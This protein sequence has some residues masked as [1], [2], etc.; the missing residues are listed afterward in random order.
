MKSPMSE[1]LNRATRN[2]R[3]ADLP[4]MVLD[5]GDL[6]ADFQA[7][8]LARQGVLDNAAMAEQ[9]FPGN[10]VETFTALGRISGYLREFVAPMPAGEVIPPGY[11]LAVA[12]V[13]HLFEAPEGVSRWMQEIFLGQFEAHVGQEIHPE[14]QLLMVERL[15]F[16]G[17]SDEVAGLRVLQS[18]PQGPVSSTVVDFR[19]GRLLGV[20]YVASF[21]NYERR[22]VV[23]QIGQA[24][25]RQCVRV[26]LGAA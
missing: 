5:L 8:L 16:Q 12:T 23:E 18:S 11:D 17:F 21:G 22:A 19:V 25:E 6:P 2:I 4:R 7:F 20:A 14:Q 3:E 26:V 13:V 24:L 15:T 9:G 1:A 10:S